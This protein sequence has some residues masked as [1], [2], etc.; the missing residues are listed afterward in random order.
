MDRRQLVLTGV[1]VVGQICAV[2]P[3][4]GAGVVCGLC[5]AY[6]SGMFGRRLLDRWADAG[7]ES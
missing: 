6:L 1:F 2:L 7:N 3:H 4:T 5:L